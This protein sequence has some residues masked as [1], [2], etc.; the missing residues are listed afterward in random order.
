MIR[1]EK[2]KALINRDSDALYKYK[3]ERDKN[4]KLISMQKDI[5]TLKHDIENL[6]KLLEGNIKKN[7]EVDN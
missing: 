3:L 1:D 2:T 5:D 6:Y 4:R 7:G